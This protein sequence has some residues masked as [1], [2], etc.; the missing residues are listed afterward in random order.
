MK[1]QVLTIADIID[2][3]DDRIMVSVTA[4]NI[5]LYNGYIENLSA[6]YCNY[7]ITEKLSISCGVLNIVLDC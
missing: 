3:L 6:I 5:P 7:P 2:M 1:K 4:Y